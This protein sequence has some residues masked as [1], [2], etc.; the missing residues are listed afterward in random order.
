MKYEENIMVINTE[1][2]S[3][4]YMKTFTRHESLASDFL[5]SKMTE[6]TK[7]Y[8]NKVHVKNLGDV[9]ING[10]KHCR[11]IITAGDVKC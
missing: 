6:L 3:G 9:S 7:K 1:F 5:E 11:F 4:Y 10:Q 2:Q 8:G